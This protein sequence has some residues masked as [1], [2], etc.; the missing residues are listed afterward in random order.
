MFNEFHEYPKMI[1]HPEQGHKVVHSREEQ[2]AH[3]G[4]FESPYEAQKAGKKPSKKGE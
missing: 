2:D 4:Y 1:Y 3:K